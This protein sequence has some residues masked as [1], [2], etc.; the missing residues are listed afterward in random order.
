MGRRLNSKDRDLSIGI[1][2]CPRCEK[3]KLFKYF[4]FYKSIQKYGSYCKDCEKK[5]AIRRHFLNKERQNNIS[6]KYYRDNIESAREKSRVNSKN[7]YKNN[8]QKIRETKKKY[9]NNKIKTDPK[10]RLRCYISTNIYQC[11]VYKGKGRKPKGWE[12]SVGYKLEDLIIHLEKQ[13]DKNM[14]WDN[15]GSY[16][17]IDH[18]IPISKFNF[19]STDHIDFKRGWALS[20]LRPLEKLA[21]QQKNNKLKSS[22]QPCLELD[23]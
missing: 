21:N 13:F 19:S 18:I 15:Y 4:Y 23:F 8:K 10:F 3:D 17:S 16:W 1:L 22:F 5:D 9:R 6:K 20:N 2:Y 14:N 11:L 7:Y 12:A